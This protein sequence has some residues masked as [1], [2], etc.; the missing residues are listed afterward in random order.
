MVFLLWWYFPR[1]PLSGSEGSRTVCSPALSC[2][3][4][5]TLALHSLYCTPIKWQFDF[6][7]VM[8][9][10]DFGCI[11]CFLLWLL[12]SQISH[13]NRVF[14]I[15]YWLKGWQDLCCR[16]K[17]ALSWNLCDSHVLVFCVV[18]FGGVWGVIF[19]TCLIWQVLDFLVFLI[20]F[21]LLVFCGL[22]PFRYLYPHPGKHQNPC[23]H[24]FLLRKVLKYSRQVPS[25]HWGLSHL[26][27]CLSFCLCVFLN[28][29]F[30][31]IFLRE[32]PFH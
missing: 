26:L 28:S 27:T 19:Q 17:Q 1:S 30:Y 20:F 21:P 11:G 8:L 24:H 10:L 22:F 12:S 29:N 9:I 13:E 3:T 14:I 23:A 16:M 32:L 4:Q 18:S 15:L 31:L 5:I 6:K 7:L 25:S 2:H